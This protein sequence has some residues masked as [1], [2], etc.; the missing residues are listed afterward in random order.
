MEAAKPPSSAGSGVE[1]TQPVRIPHRRRTCAKICLRIV[2]L[3]TALSALTFLIALVAHGGSITSM[4][5]TINFSMMKLFRDLSRVKARRRRFGQKGALMPVLMGHEE[6]LPIADATTGLM[7]TLEELAEFDGRR[8]PDSD[9]RAL[10]YLAIHGRI[11]DVTAGMPFYG[12][13]R[14]YHKLVGK[15]ATR[16]FC[17]GCLELDCLISNTRGLTPKQLKEADRWIELYEHHD[18]YKLVGAVRTPSLAE[19]S[20]G[21]ADE[22]DDPEEF[23]KAVQKAEAEWE[24]ELVERAMAAEGAKK[25]RPFRLR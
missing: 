15:D 11:Y 10:L 14:S 13:G 5:A 22:A 8:L 24:D 7:M 16:A 12:P 23:A 25:H 19:A 21:A 9:E 1:A 3:L 17:T 18:K 6:A 2:L 4:G 20:D